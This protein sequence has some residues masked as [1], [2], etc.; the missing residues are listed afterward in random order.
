MQWLLIALT[1]QNQTPQ[2]AQALPS[3]WDFPRTT[4]IVASLLARPTR[5]LSGVLQP[6]VMARHG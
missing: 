1:Q 4:A 5:P 6:M 3:G 2:K